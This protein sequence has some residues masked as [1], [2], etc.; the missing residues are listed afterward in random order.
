M[1]I[2]TWNVNSIAVR[3]PAVTA[4]LAEHAPDALCLQEIKT[5]DARFPAA[6]FAEVGYQ[7]VTYGQPTYNGVAILA[8]RPP[9]DVERGFP[10]EDSSP[11][12][13]IAATVGSVRVINVYV[14][15]GAP[16]GSDRYT[17]K[18]AWLA[19]LGAY[20]AT[21]HS[22]EE[23]LVLCGD[24][25]VATEPRDVYDPVVLAQEVL[26]TPAERA[27]LAP[28]AA[29]GLVDTFRLHEEGAGHYS[30]WDYRQN[31]FRRDRGLRIDHIWATPP[32]AAFCTSVRI[33]R[34]ARAGERPSDHAPVVADFGI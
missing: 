31:N 5:V 21:R 15:N 11:A 27:A 32:L 16:L 26:F 8:R 19:Q 20:L 10:G 30:W 28:L 12:R 22:P 13:L 4:W 3:L 24:F 1:R 9:T 25:N 14:P 34:A 23:P 17:G 33:D 7:A 18:L 2:A 6:A 29:W